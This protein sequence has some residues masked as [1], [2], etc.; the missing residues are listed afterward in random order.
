MYLAWWGFVF[1]MGIPGVVQ[2][3]ASHS[4]H[5]AERAGA[6][7]AAIATGRALAPAAYTALAT[8]LRTV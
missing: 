7:Q 6:A 1:W 2:M 5:P 3:L 4:L 8:M